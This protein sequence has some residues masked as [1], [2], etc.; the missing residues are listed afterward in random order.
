MAGASAYQKCVQLRLRRA[1]AFVQSCQGHDAHQLKVFKW[2]KT[3]PKQSRQLRTPV[4]SCVLNMQKSIL[5][6]FDTFLSSPKRARDKRNK[7]S[8]HW[9]RPTLMSLARRPHETVLWD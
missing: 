9:Q 6:E 5:Y 3:K 8:L 1:C 4:I 2:M 7:I